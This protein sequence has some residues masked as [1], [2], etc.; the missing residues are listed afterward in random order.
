[1]PKNKTLD[2]DNELKKLSMGVYTGNE[3][4]L[5]KNGIKINEYD[6]KQINSG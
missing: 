4:C 6:N 2:F 5:Q 1:M 3:K